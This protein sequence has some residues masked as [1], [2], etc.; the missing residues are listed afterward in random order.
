M[1]IENFENDFIRNKFITKK[2]LKIL[3]EVYFNFTDV[4]KLGKD[5]NNDLA[6]ILSTINTL[7]S[8]LLEDIEFCTLMINDK[9]LIKKVAEGG[10][11]AIELDI[12]CHLFLIK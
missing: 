3:R 7:F 2:F 11:G 10:N 12:S 9:D 5:S 4:R 8:V 6:G 1:I